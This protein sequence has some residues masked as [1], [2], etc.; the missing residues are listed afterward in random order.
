MVTNSMPIA[1]S[2]KTAF[3]SV[4]V[5]TGLST[6]TLLISMSWNCK[7]IRVGAGS[8]LHRRADHVSLSSTFW[9]CTHEGLRLRGVAKG[10]LEQALGSL[11]LLAVMIEICAQCPPIPFGP[12]RRLTI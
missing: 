9:R 11:V 10:D 12:T 5:L 1:S 2:R 7:V 3:V 6:E 4:P 8:P